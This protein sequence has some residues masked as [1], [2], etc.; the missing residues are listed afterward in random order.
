MI[1]NSKKKEELESVGELPG[2]CSKIVLQCLWS[3]NKLARSFT[4]WTQACDRRLARLLSNIHHTSDYR[5]YCHAGYMAQHRRLGLF[6]DSDFAGDLDNSKATSER[7]SCIFGSRTCVTIWWMCKKQASVSHSSAESEIISLDAGL[8]MDG[9]L[10]LE[11]WDVVIEV[12]RSTNSTKTPTN[13]A[14]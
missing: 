3:V 7:I 11:L 14:S 4:K 5:Q 12:L 10:A 6:Q 2:V 8:R 13:P 1:I 9:L